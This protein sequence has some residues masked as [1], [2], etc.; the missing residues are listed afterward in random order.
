MTQMITTPTTRVSRA[1]RM[2]MPLARDVL[3]DVAVDA[4]RVH[5][6]GPAAPPQ[7]GYR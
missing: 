4:R 7:P 6:P 2:A 1:E 3:R 5:P